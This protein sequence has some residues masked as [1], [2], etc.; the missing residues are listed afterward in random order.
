MPMPMVSIRYVRVVVNEAGR[1]PDDS[2]GHAAGASRAIAKL[3]VVIMSPAL[4]RAV[5]Q[6]RAGVE[7]ASGY[8]H[9]GGNAGDKNRHRAV[10]ESAVAKLAVSI[11]PPALDRAAV[12]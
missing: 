6:H 2:D 10:L 9:S 11:V 3:A 1:M 5:A 7:H 4:N 12:E 8:C